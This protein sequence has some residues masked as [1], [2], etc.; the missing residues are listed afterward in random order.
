MGCSRN[1]VSVEKPGGGTESSSI[2]ILSSRRPWIAEATSPASIVSRSCR[3][4]AL[5]MADSMADRTGFLFAA[6]VAGK[7]RDN[8]TDIRSCIGSSACRR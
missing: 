6:K 7:P 4:F 2:L 1:F 5:R 8:G 3:V